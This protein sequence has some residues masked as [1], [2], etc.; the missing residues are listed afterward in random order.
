MLVKSVV[1]GG[2]NQDE[3]W[4]EVASHILPEILQEFNYEDPPKIIHRIVPSTHIDD[5]WSLEF[6]LYHRLFGYQLCNFYCQ[7]INSL[8]FFIYHCLNLFAMFMPLL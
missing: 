6:I 4:M 2:L 1:A 3:G 5:L 7:K 8:I